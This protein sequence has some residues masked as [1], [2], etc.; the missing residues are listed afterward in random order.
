MNIMPCYCGSKESYSMCCQPFILEQKYPETPEQLM[1]SR[2]SAYATS[3][4][5]YIFNTYAKEKHKEHTVTDI[6]N[7]A[8]TTQWLSLKVNHATAITL[9]QFSPNTLPTVNFDA[10]YRH[11]KHYYKMSES[12]RFVVEDNQWRYLD[13]D[14]AEHTELIQPKRNDNCF[15]DSGKKFKKCCGK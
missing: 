3:N 15:C 12:S 8:Q 5:Q 13:G 14:V 7:W 2:Y 11:E 9:K 10:Y 6:L 1:R 4:A